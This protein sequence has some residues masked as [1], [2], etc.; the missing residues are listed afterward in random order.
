MVDS[1]LSK[2]VLATVGGREFP[3]VCLSTFTPKTVWTQYR[4]ASK[5]SN[6]LSQ[7][8]LWA[9]YFRHHR[10]SINDAAVSRRCQPA[11]TYSLLGSTH[12]T[13]TSSV[14]AETALV[15]A[16]KN[17]LQLRKDRKKS[18]GAVICR[19]EHCDATTLCS[20]KLYNS[21]TVLLQ[22]NVPP[23]STWKKIL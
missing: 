22:C 23:Y 21:F 16:T 13:C 2:S 8:Q 18:V 6:D 7:Q 17:R 12:C 19:V 9:S 5:R 4:R 11:A 14:L 10:C 1:G 20:G 15:G 3:W